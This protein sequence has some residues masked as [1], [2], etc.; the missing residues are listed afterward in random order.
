VIVVRSWF[1]SSTVWGSGSNSCC[2]AQW[3]HLYGSSYLTGPCNYFRT[4]SY[5][6][7]PPQ[8]SYI[9]PFF[10]PGVTLT[11]QL[12]FPYIGLLLLP[13]SAF[14]ISVSFIILSHNIKCVCVCVLCV[15]LHILYVSVC[16]YVWVYLL[17]C[18]C[19][20]VC[21]YVYVHVCIFVCVSVYLSVCLYSMCVYVSVSI[22]V[23]V[24]LCVCIFLCLCICMWVS[25]WVFVCLCVSVSMSVYLYVC[26]CIFFSLFSFFRSWEPNPGP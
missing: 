7:L 25:V 11:P 26:L 24:Y 8:A 10:L 9:Y 1:S 6:W 17:V 4:P 5:R 19:V 16:V 13:G 14:H 3:Q 12:K 20:F 15:Y 23:S 2:H 18:V 21:V 22:C